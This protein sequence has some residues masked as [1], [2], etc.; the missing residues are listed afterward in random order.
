[1][2][3]VGAA[4]AAGTAREAAAATHELRW[5]YDEPDRPVLVVVLADGE[6]VAEVPVEDPAD[7]NGVFTTFVSVPSGSEVQIQ[8]QDASGRISDPS[9]VQIYGDDCHEWDSDGDGVVGASDLSWF[10]L[11]YADGLASVAE[12]GLFRKVFGQACAAGG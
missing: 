12:F 5:M 6:N 1:V 9:N 8:V 4:C 7:E 11:E 10:R 3:L 2:L